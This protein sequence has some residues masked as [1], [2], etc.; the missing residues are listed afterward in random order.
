[1]SFI[2]GG[3]EGSAFQPE[4]CSGD[5]GVFRRVRVR[6]FRAEALNGRRE[7]FLD[8]GLSHLYDF[9][10]F[11]LVEVRET[12]QR[13]FEFALPHAFRVRAEVGDERAYLKRLEIFGEGFFFFRE[14]GFDERGFF[15]AKRE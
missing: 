3:V 11:F 14:N 8:E 7:E 15:F 13:F 12:A 5:S 1:M 9:P 10:A 2:I 4:E 6:G